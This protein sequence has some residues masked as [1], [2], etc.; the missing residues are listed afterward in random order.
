MAVGSRF[1]ARVQTGPGTHPAFCKMG[2]GTF[3]GVKSGGGVTLTPN[4]LLVPWSIKGRAISLL[5]LWAVRPLQSLSVCTRV[6]F[7]LYFVPSLLNTWQKHCSSCLATERQVAA[8]FYIF[9]R[10]KQPLHHKWVN[11]RQQT[12]NK[13]GCLPMRW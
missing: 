12:S 2:T 3:P 13:L 8:N 5:P 6:H 7:I 11:K 1:F 9:K 10:Q 4:P